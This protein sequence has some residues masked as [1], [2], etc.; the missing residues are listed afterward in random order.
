M[1]LTYRVSIAEWYNHYN[2]VIMG[3]MTSQITIITI[4]YSTIYSGADQRKHQSSASLA[5]PR[6][7]WPVNSPHKWPVTRKMF[8][9]NDIIKIPC[10]GI[11]DYDFNELMDFWNTGNARIWKGFPYIKHCTAFNMVYLSRY[12]YIWLELLFM[13]FMSFMYISSLHCTHYTSSPILPIWQC[14]LFKYLYE[15]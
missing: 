4:V 13:S 15:P 14:C 1:V 11:A 2:D 8:P 6:H 3:V 10:L 9:F 7:W 5:T 12:I